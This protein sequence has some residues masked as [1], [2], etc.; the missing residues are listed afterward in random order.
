MA[1]VV[2]AV[3]GGASQRFG[4]QALALVV[5]DGVDGHAN[6]LGDGIDGK[7]SGLRV[8]AKNPDL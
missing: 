8:R 1:P 3:A 4:Q 2:A 6:A 7:R 5:T